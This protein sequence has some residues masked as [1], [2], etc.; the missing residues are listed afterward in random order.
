[1]QAFVKAIQTHGPSPVSAEEG[2]LGMA[3]VL[4]ASASVDQGKIISLEQHRI[5]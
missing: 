3:A 4:A 2:R 1:V 5:K